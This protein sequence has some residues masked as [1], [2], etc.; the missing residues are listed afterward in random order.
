MMMDSS[1]MSPHDGDPHDSTSL[2]V[3]FMLSED[4]YGGLTDIIKVGEGSLTFDKRLKR[5]SSVTMNS[6]SLDSH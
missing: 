1:M 4:A 5:F 2:S 6:R 3:T